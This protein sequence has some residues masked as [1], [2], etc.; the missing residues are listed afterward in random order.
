MKGLAAASIESLRAARAAGCEQWLHEEIAGVLAGADAALLDRLL[1]GS[2]HHAARRVGEMRDARELL[3]ELRVEPRVAA[4]AE[5][6]L[7]TLE[8]ERGAGG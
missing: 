4:A 3:G 1:T 5:S 6:W 2:V 7:A 8:R